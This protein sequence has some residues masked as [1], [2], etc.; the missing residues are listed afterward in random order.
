MLNKHFGGCVKVVLWSGTCDISLIYNAFVGSLDGR[1]GIC[2]VLIRSVLQILVIFR[3][4]LM[5]NV[6]NGHLVSF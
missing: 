2:L 4:L 1:K 5:L 6:V 3:W